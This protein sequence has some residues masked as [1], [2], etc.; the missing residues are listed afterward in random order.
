MRSR[1]L[2]TAATAALLTAGIAVAL[3]AAANAA[4]PVGPTL[5]I[6]LTVSADAPG[7]ALQPGGPTETVTIKAANTTAKAA[8][9]NLEDV[10]VWSGPL[11]PKPGSLSL[12]VTSEGATPATGYS[13][14]QGSFGFGLDA[15]VFP[16]GHP[17]GAFTIPARTTFEWQ[18]S[19]GVNKNWPANDGKVNLW[20]TFEEQGKTLH[21][22]GNYGTQLSVGQGTTGGP[23]LLSLS[24]GTKVAPGR[25][26]WEKVTVTN[27]SGAKIAEPLRVMPY[28]FAAGPVNQ[29][30]LGLFEWV[31]AHGNVKAHWQ[32]VTHSGVVVAAG[33]ANNASASTWLELRVVSYK[34]TAASEAGALVV[35][36][37]D[38]LPTTEDQARESLTVLR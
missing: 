7:K 20:V 29:V 10:S 17:D 1:T 30:N 14:S 31:G 6:A 15:T 12:K 35:S 26:A 18:V 22:H 38:L 5:P 32:D 2:A 4:A 24:G 25:P 11:A 23:V 28:A 37:P 3:P 36:S 27:H 33:V 16:K 21:G 19:V 13:L 9:I 34:A 8:D